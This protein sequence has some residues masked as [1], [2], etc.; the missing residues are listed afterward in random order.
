VV[1]NFIITVLEVPKLQTTIPQKGELPAPITLIS[2]ISCY[3]E[4]KIKVYLFAC[5]KLYIILRTFI[6][7]PKNMF[8]N[9]LFS[10]FRR[11]HGVER[12]WPLPWYVA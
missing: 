4:Y 1:T 5:W 9:K 3:L 2:P 6:P 10:L 11:N 8:A 7:G 12:L